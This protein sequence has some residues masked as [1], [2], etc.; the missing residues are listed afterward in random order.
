MYSERKTSVS[1]IQIDDIKLTPDFVAMWLVI[2]LQLWF[3]CLATI[4]F[5]E[6]RILTFSGFWPLLVIV[7][8]VRAINSIYL[9]K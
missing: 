2:Y 1:I 9:Y 7:E 6:N 4:E 3:R 5:I 8:L